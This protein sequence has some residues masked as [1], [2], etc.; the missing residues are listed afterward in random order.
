MIPIP[1]IDK[2][3]AL[4]FEDLQALNYI[5]HRHPATSSAMADSKNAEQPI[6]F[7][8]GD[9]IDWKQRLTALLRSHQLD[10]CLQASPEDTQQDLSGQ[11]RDAAALSMI[12]TLVHRSILQ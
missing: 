1:N 5:R 8:G 12:T 9:F 2:Q 4:Q 6:I 11:A 7:Y 10:R 3:R